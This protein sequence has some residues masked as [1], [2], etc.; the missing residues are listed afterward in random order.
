MASVISRGNNYWELRVSCGYRDGKQIRI[1]KRIKATSLRAAR[2]E[3][4]KFCLEVS[5]RPRVSVDSKMKFGEFVEVWDKKHNSKLS[6]LTREH[7]KR[8][9]LRINDVFASTPMK[10][11][12]GSQ[13]VD[14]IEMLRHTR[15]E[16]G[17]DEKVVYLSKTSVHQYFKLLNHIF[18]KAV[19]WE[20]IGKNPCLEIPRSQWPKPEY[21]HH[22]V[23]NEDELHRFLSIIERLPA[24]AS[25]MKY[26][27]MLYLALMGGMRK[28]EICGL[29]WDCVDFDNCT[30]SVEKAQKYVNGKQVE[31]GRP[32]T[33]GSIRKLYFDSYT[34]GLLR[35]HKEFQETWLCSRGY[36]N[37]AGYVFLATRLREGVMVPVSPNSLNGWM[38]KII[39]DSGLP[40]VTVHSLRHMAAT[41]ALNNGAPLTSVQ[42]MLGHS[43]VRTTSIYL[44]PLEGQRKKTARV[45][46]GC[47]SRIREGS[48]QVVTL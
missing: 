28:G 27:A 6:L 31:L 15:V 13:V 18:S 48:L 9:L 41:Y 11:I 32:K 35:Q 36:T 33:D 29:T 30:V 20:V 3:L 8:L 44:H 17:D 26:K 2:K 43:S 22:P 23:W 45:L 19:E 10:Q 37:P 14:F 5:E 24:S 42:A 34:M 47:I 12:R 16:R 40:H 4:E 1:T 38:D 7:H 25:N 21:H 46:S 39:E